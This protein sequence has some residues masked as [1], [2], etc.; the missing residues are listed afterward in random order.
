MTISKICYVLLPVLYS[1]TESAAC[2]HTK[3]HCNSHSQHAELAIYFS[4]RLAACLL[5]MDFESYSTLLGNHF[6]SK[7][8]ADLWNVSKS[9][10]QS[11]RFPGKDGSLEYTWL[12][13][14]V[15]FG[16]VLSPD[17]PWNVGDNNDRFSIK[18]RGKNRRISLQFRW[19]CWAGHRTD[20]RASELFKQI[21]HMKRW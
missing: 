4:T 8:L 14:T 5:F 13:W 18:G 1:G 16:P 10:Y 11:K 20:E 21:T 17:L 9:H 3:L 6:R 2:R 15:K 19:S 7:I 12:G